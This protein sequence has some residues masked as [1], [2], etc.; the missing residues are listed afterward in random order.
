MTELNL[1]GV[2][3]K[4]PTTFKDYD[5]YY[6]KNSDQAYIAIGNKWV[7][8]NASIDPDN[9]DNNVDVVEKSTWKGSSPISSSDV[10]ACVAG[11]GC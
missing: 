7:M 9:S 4:Q 8:Y 2:L 5:I 11:L 10:C 3:D 6:D 1:L